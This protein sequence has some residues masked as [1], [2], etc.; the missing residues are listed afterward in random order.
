V[1]LPCR[2][3]MTESPLLFS[4]PACGSFL[5]CC[6]EV[7]GQK[8]QKWETMADDAARGAVRKGAHGSSTSARDRQR[9]FT[10]LATLATLSPRERAVAALLSVC[11]NRGNKARMFMK[12]KGNDKKSGGKSRASRHSRE[13]GNPL[14]RLWVPAFAGTTL[15]FKIDGTKPECL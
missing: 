10:R 15:I 5:V 3:G 14:Y 4:V 11:E 9:P 13:G 6:Q 2:L 7:R 8:V 12:T 1:V